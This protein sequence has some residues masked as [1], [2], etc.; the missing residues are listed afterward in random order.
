[1]GEFALASLGVFLVV[2]TLALTGALVEET[3]NW[4][5]YRR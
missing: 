4:W 1:M 5:R 2:C 3:Y